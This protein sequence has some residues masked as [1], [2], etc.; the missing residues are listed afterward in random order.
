M[1]TVHAS[2]FIMPGLEPRLLQKASSS[3]AG[4]IHIELEDGVPDD[5]K[6]EARLNFVA[7]LQELDWRGKETMVRINSVDSGFVEDDLDVVTAG[8]PKIFLLAKCQGP[9]DIRYVERLVTRAERKHGLTE[10]SIQLAAMIERARA[11]SQVDEIAAASPRMMALYLGPG[12]LGNELGYRRSYQPQELETLWVRS[13]V[14]FAAHTADLL[15][16]DAPYLGSRP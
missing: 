15:A 13:R 6:Q 14:I 3:K 7:A 12:D 8:R 10:G 9:D 5:R 4:Y 16:I 2:G 1:A 11:L